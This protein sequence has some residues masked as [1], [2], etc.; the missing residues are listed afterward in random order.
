M[1]RLHI[2]I[3]VDKLDDAVRFYNTLLGAE[4]VKLEPDYAKWMLDDP[5][6]NF[7]VSTRTSR[8]G[9]DHLGIQVDEK[10]ELDELRQRL[11]AP[12]M[13]VI[14][15]GET[16]CCYA[17]SDK[18]WIEDPAGVPWEAYRT[19]ADAQLYHA[20]GSAVDDAC[21][22]AESEDE[23]DCCEASNKT[24]PCCG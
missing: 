19:M 5:C 3:G 4:P 2:H 21:C 22:A 11:D 15:E 23:A 8:K 13:T 16:V 14:E 18:S 7:A 12:G 10:E 1:K 6:V 24:A 17:R 9:V 20:E